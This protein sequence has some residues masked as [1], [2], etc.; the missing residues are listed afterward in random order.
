MWQEWGKEDLQQYN[1]I[2]KKYLLADNLPQKWEVTQ[3]E[4]LIGND[5]YGD[6]VNRRKIQLDEGLYLIDS[7]LGWLIN[8]KIKQPVNTSFDTT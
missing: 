3:I 2:L 6:L 5:Y 1:L 7:K 8:R 4:L